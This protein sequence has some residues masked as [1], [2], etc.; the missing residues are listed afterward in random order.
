MWETFGSGCSIVKSSLLE[1][2]TFD[3]ALEFGYGEDKD[4]GIQIR[5]KSAAVIYISDYPI[6]H[7]KAPIGGFRQK[8]QKPWD[9]D[10]LKPK[11]SP[12]ILFYIQKNHSIYQQ[13]GYK[14]F[15][16]IKQLA[17]IK[18]LISWRK[19]LKAWRMSEYWVAKIRKA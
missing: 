12:T 17:T 18:G 8:I 13:K 14:C 11:P 7:L 16:L 2:L 3:L 15:Y 6:F 19:I 9:F 10:K 4:Y 1:D 5:K